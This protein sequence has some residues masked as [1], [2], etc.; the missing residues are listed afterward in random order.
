MVAGIGYLVYSAS[1]SEGVVYKTASQIRALGPSSQSYRLT[2]HAKKGS[3]VRIPSERK[4]NF[5]IIDHENIEMKATYSGIIPD[6][7]K[8]SSEVVISGRYN[9]SED[10]FV[11]ND[12]LAKCPSKYQ[13]RYD[14]SLAAPASD[15]PSPPAR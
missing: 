11:G 10:L 6:T 5:A 4:V 15:A 2:G 1:N 8:D 14:T 3:I 12:L 7:F 13:G 9:A